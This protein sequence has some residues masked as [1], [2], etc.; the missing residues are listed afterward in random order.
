MSKIKLGIVGYGN[1]GKSVEIGIN[2]HED[3]EVVGVFTRRDPKTVKT[4]GEDTKG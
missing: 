1:L 3:M 4:A 2:Q